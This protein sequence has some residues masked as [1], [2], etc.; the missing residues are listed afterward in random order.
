MTTT[1]GASSEAIQ[2]H[3]D[4]ANDFYAL[5]LDPSM[6]YTC[7][8]FDEGETETALEAAQ[9]RKIDHHAAQA[10]IAAGARVLDIGCGWGGML[11]RFVDTH[12]AAAGVGLT[13]SR[14]QKAW[15]AEAPD[16]RLEIRLENWQDHRPAA[17]Y[18]AIVSI[19]AMEAF[20]RPG[21]STA[22]RIAIYAG[23]FDRCRE[24]LKPGGAFSLQTIA[25][26]NSRS[27]DLDPFISQ[28]IFPESDLPRLAEIA[29]AIEHRF[30]IVRLVN[31]RAQYLRTIRAWLAG[32]RRTRTQAVGLVGEETVLRY[33]EYLR[34]C[35]TMFASGSCDLY[36]IALRRIDRPFVTRRTN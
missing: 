32:L 5:W 22:E 18:D 21:Q 23:L 11:R 6:T 15:I 8:L 30:E 12:G 33:E 4:L 7:A 25:Y 27:E 28:K 16:P 9:R 35:T 24:W 2:F 34:L 1:K 10:G 29:Q 3:Y 31:D 20:V 19:E 26:G 14:E 36:R 17:P 13:L